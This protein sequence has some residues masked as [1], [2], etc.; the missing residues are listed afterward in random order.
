MVKSKETLER[1]YT[2]ANPKSQAQF[3]DSQG[4]MPSGVAKSTSAWNPF[5]IYIDRAQDCYM[6]DID[7]HRY[8]DFNNS[9]TALILGHSP[10]TVV[11][12]M[13]KLVNNGIVFGP[14]SVYEKLASEE[15]VKRVPSVKSVRWANSGTEAVMN[16]LRLARA[17]TGKFKI[18]KFEGAFHGTSDDAQVSHA[19]SI[20]SA[21]PREAP[22]AIADQ[23]GAGRRVAEDIVV[24]PYNDRESVELIL[25]EH[26]DDLAALIYEPKAGGYDIPFDFVQ[27][28]EKTCNDLGILFIMDEVK[29]FRVSY[30]GYQELAGVSPDLSVFGKLVGGGLPVGAFGGRQ[31]IMDL[32]DGT[33][34]KSGISSSGTYSGHALTLA[35]GWATMKAATPEVYD[36]MKQLNDR[37]AKGVGDVFTRAQIP[38]SIVSHNNIMT[39]HLTDTPI[40]DY[41]SASSK[42]T[43]DLNN[44]LSLALMMEGY[45]AR[46]LSELTISEPM[47]E[48]IIDDFITTLERVIHEED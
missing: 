14:P 23:R 13:S 48:T 35:A 16:T 4:V 17:F 43:G 2:E 31:D 39:A 40:R 33:K 5:P 15:I 36:Y 27:F 24:L 34:G 10:K 22:N 38:C 7:G 30:G 44:R 29:H 21:G 6:W 19:P 46:G 11:E 25:Q 9:S 37:L 8:L 42:T 1:L 12:E 26:K 32:L 18:A 47:T 45:L 28:V 3:V 41:R 20:D